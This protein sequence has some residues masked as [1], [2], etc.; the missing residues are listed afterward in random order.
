VLRGRAP[1]QLGGQLE[2]DEPDS[3][4]VI[5]GSYLEPFRY[6]VEVAR[7]DLE[8]TFVSDHRPLQAYTEAI[9]AARLPIELLREPAMP[10]SAE[11]HWRKWQ[12]VPMFLHGRAVKPGG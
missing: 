7:D 1:D 6:A 12:R 8:M 9:A 2:S 10:E 3:R 4:F 5:E 11:S